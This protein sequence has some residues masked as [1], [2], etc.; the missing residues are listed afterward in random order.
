ML[1]CASYALGKLSHD[2]IRS[3]LISALVTGDTIQLFC[4]DHSIIIVAKAVNIL[5]EPSQF[6]A[7]LQAI[8][9]LTLPQLGYADIMK[10]TSLSDNP[11]QPID[12]FNGL[13]LTLS[14]GTSFVLGST[15]YHQRG[16]IG[17]GTCVV[18]ARYS[19]WSKAHCGDDNIWDGPLVVKLSW[20]VKSKISESNIIAKAYNAAN[21]DE[22]RWVLKHLPNILHAEDRHINLLP[23]A[24]I[25][26]LGDRY[27]ERVLRI[28]VQ[29][30]LYPITE[31]TVA[32]DLAQSFLE[33]FKC[34]RWLYEVPK[35]LH[36]DISPNNLMIRKEGGK[37]YGVLNDFDLA[38]S[39]DVKRESSLESPKKYGN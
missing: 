35:I 5:E 7:M 22:H 13:E 15:I 9:N 20:Q 17:R 36:R 27:E 18:R 26:R 14:G 30:E 2:G 24:L 33:V 16:I 25:D 23:R 11:R 31:R 1:Q 32:V 3:H 34:Y 21:H 10:P 38:V 8:S 37:V 4:N 28:M 19:N 39:A 12:I 29:E 6:V